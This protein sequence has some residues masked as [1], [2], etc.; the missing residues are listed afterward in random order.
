MM[1]SD[2]F[3]NINDHY[4]HIVGD[5]VLATSAR[6]IIEH[7]R[8]CDKVFRYGG[9][10]FLLLIQQIELK[11]GY[12]L[13]EKLRKELRAMIINTGREESIRITVSFGLTLLDPY[14]SVEQLIDPADKAVFGA[15]SAG[16]NWV[17]IFTA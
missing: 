5:Q 2:H 8:S 16:R 9:G 17:K 12:H 3:K 7:L 14:S 15:K 13:V 10:E 6:C 4:G 11:P 1:D